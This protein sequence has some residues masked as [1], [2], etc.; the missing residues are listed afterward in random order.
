MCTATNSA[1]DDQ[2]ATLSK[3]RHDLC[4]EALWEIE[5]L[6]LA[7]PGLVPMNDENSPHFVVRGIARRL[8]GLSRSLMTALDD[9]DVP[10]DT[11]RRQV[12]FG[13]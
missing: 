7:L 11:V 13:Q 3:D 4:L 6:S 1:T 10:D 12:F 2:A 5:A 9:P 8:V